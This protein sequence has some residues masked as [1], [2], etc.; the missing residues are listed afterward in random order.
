MA[1]PKSDNSTSDNDVKAPN[2]IERAKEGIEA[3]LHFKKSPEHQHHKETHGTSEDIDE[4]TPVGEVKAP[5]VFERAKEEVEAIVQAIHPK[6]E[7]TSHGESKKESDGPFAS[8][9]R[10]FEKICSP[11]HNDDY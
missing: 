10:R 2:V 4:D 11:R 5:N 3:F 9:G 1:E 8:I 6:K 7:S